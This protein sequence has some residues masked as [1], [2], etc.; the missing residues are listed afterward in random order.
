MQSLPKERIQPDVLKKQKE[1]AVNRFTSENI[2][3][4][5]NSTQAK[6]EETRTFVTQKGNIF[7]EIKKTTKK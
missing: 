3:C 5:E 7:E 4:V 1:N 6:K 2:A